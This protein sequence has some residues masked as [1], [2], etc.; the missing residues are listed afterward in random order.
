MRPGVLDN[1]IHRPFLTALG[2]G[3]LARLKHLHI[4][5]DPRWG[6]TA[7]EEA[8][9]TPGSL[10]ALRTLRLFC[11]AEDGVIEALLSAAGPQLTTLVAFNDTASATV[12]KRRWSATSPRWRGFDLSN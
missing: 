5:G 8:T 12:S 4:D 9:I 3:G 1:R 7:G 2:S 6:G 11:S 10:P